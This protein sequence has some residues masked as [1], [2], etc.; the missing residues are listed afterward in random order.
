MSMVVHLL[1]ACLSRYIGR[2]EEENPGIGRNGTTRFRVER[3]QIDCERVGEEKA[4]SNKFGD[5]NK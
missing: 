3:E 2:E 1:Y 4:I 5:T